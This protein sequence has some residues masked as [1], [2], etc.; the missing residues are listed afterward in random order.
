MVQRL[1]VLAFLLLAS[2]CGSSSSSGPTPPAPA[3]VPPLVIR[4]GWTEA[5]VSAVAQPPD[6]LMG[7][8]LL[9]TAPGYLDRE[10]TRNGSVVYLWPGESGYVGQLVYS[11]HGRLVKWTSGRL[12]VAL[13]PFQESEVGPAASEVGAKTGMVVEFAESGQV[14]LS[15]DP[16]DPSVQGARAAT[17]LEMSGS[18]VTG[19]RVVCRSRGDCLA[20]STLLHELG[21]VVGLSHV[22]DPTSVM[23]PSSTTRP[24]TFSA[25]E[26]VTLR[27]MYAHRFP[28]NL[29]P[30]RDPGLGASSSPYPQT[31]VIRD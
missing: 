6:G 29:P 11:V 5:L 27:L 23:F 12:N 4:D 24:D 3:P 19:A 17:Y 13:G 9:L 15:V 2:G 21:H 30:D 1:A 25:N 10:T 18:V 8:R 31:I 14:R 22:D 26:R 20:F 16:A 28:G 7:S